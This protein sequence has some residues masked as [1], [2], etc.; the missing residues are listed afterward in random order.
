[1]YKGRFIHTA[2]T[3]TFIMLDMQWFKLTKQRPQTIHNDACVQYTEVSSVYMF[4][5]R[6][7]VAY[8]Q[9]S[10]KIQQEMHALLVCLDARMTLVL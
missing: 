1:M 3:T 8:M 6:G 4:W 10:K 5:I 2:C 9:G 7:C